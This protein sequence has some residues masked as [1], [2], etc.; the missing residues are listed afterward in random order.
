[1]SI[2]ATAAGDAWWLSVFHNQDLMTPEQAA[3]I[4][5]LLK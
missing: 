4:A 1:M 2:V 3:Q 5:G